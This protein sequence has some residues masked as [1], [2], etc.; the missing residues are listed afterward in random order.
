[1]GAA[2]ESESRGRKDRLA[3]APLTWLCSVVL[4][5]PVWE[6]MFWLSICLCGPVIVWSFS[7]R[8]DGPLLSARRGEVTVS[9]LPPANYIGERSCVLRPSTRQTSINT[10]DLLH[11]DESERSLTS[12]ASSMISTRLL[13]MGSVAVAGLVYVSTPSSDH[14]RLLRAMSGQCVSL[15]S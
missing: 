11:S 14:S 1:M 13:A 15:A 2:L 9:S 4:R 3:V 8:C 6:R 7:G 5:V 12:M 10:R